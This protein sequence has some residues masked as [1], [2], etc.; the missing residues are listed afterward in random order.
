MVRNE[1]DGCL[2]RIEAMA[3]GMSGVPRRIAEAILQASGSVVAMSIADFAKSVGVSEASVVRFARAVGYSGFG[4]LKISLA[5][6]LGQQKPV[7]HEDVRSSDDLKTVLAKVFGANIRALNETLALGEVDSIS[8]A[9]E[10]IK[11][12]S[13]V[14]FYA[15]GNSR[16]IA[17]DSM[18]RF[19]RIGIKAS[20][21]F[22]GAV[23]LLSA[24]LLGPKDVAIGITFSGRSR[25]VV[26]ALQVAKER[27]AKV[28]VVTGLSDSPAARTGD[29]CIHTAS[30][31]GMFRTDAMASRIAQLSVLDAIY[32][33]V[34]LQ[35]ESESLSNLQFLDRFQSED[36]YV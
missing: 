4:A 32:V 3:S 1:P 21:E 10:L 34:A 11:N 5:K 33:A 9:V 24:R 15:T 28:I 12:A 36:K 27:G 35:R 6:A 18:Y 2:T 8:R 20:A 31:E 25:K 7:I 19:L 14:E 22:D 16:P 17:L 13:R 23:Q 30:P 29:V 26:N